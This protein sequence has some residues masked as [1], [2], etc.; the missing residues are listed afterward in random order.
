MSRAS[1]VR[2]YRGLEYIHFP[3]REFIV[4]NRMMTAQN[5]IDLI[6]SE[7]G[8]FKNTTKV[9]LCIESFKMK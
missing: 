3:I 6:S 1:S 2:K 5:R 7:I 8:M 9:A 4:E